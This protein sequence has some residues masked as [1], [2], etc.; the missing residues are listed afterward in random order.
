MPVVD[1]SEVELA[2]K[3]LG[4]L[5]KVSMPDEGMSH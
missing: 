2:R 5:L 4:S 3:H 1:K